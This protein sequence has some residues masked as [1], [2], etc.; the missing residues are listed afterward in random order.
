V[1]NFSGTAAT[2]AQMQA[3]IASLITAME[4]I[5]GFGA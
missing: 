1:A 2:T 5:G 3:A 4:R